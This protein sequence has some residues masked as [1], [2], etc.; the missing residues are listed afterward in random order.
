MKT[1]QYFTVFPEPKTLCVY[2]SMNKRYLEETQKEK[3][4]SVRTALTTVCFS[5]VK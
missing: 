3:Q 2:Y 4:N 5:L 1:S